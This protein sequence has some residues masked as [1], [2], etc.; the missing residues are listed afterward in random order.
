MFNFLN[1]FGLMVVS[2]EQ[3]HFELCG[4]SVRLGIVINKSDRF[5]SIH[6]SDTGEVESFDDT[7]MSELEQWIYMHGFRPAIY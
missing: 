5:V 2:L 6:V 3:W 4:P 1:Q 7:E